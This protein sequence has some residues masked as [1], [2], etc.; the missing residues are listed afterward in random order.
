MIETSMV[1]LLINVVIPCRPSARRGRDAAT[2]QMAAAMGLD[3]LNPTDGPML[4]FT[5]GSIQ[6]KAWANSAGSDV[7]VTT[8][9]REFSCEAE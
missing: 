6:V 7:S 8:K 3:E 1:L 9:C 5:A 2:R 4:I